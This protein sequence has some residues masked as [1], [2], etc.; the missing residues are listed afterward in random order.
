[1]RLFPVV[2]R[3]RSTKMHVEKRSSESWEILSIRAN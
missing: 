3:A 2:W 1:V